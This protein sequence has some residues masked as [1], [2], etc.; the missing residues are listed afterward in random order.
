M[1]ANYGTVNVNMLDSLIFGC[2]GNNVPSS[3]TVEVVGVDDSS[4][5]I[6]F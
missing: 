3:G 4:A 2:A 5:S 1:V 6:T